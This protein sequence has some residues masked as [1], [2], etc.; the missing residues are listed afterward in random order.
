MTPESE[1][2]VRHKS[3]SPAAHYVRDNA[4]IG[5]RLVLIHAILLRSHIDDGNVF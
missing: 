1:F 4:R 5:S 2:W 3:F